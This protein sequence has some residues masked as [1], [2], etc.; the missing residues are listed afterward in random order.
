MCA[1]CRRN[2][3]TVCTHC[4]KNVNGKQAVYGHERH[5]LDIGTHR[6]T[7]KKRKKKI[8]P[9][10]RLQTSAAAYRN[11]FSS[12]FIFR[13]I[14]ITNVHK[15]NCSVYVTIFYV[16]QRIA[17]VLYEQAAIAY[18]RLPSV[19]SIR[20]NRNNY[21]YNVITYIIIIICVYSEEPCRKLGMVRVVF[22]RWSPLQQ[23][24]C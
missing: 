10:T 23:I 20:T 21:N 4:G 14:Y 5:L 8:H 6:R 19:K 12:F 2:A 16:V 24:G 1:H 18:N 3:E 13:P 9:T 17:A 15:I 7:K 22:S 11:G